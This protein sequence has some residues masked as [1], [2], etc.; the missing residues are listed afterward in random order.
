MND[1][2]WVQFLQEVLPRLHL[3]WQGFRKVR[4]QVCKRIGRRLRELGL[5]DIAAYADYLAA[6]PEEWQT[7]DRLCRISISRFY[8]DRGVFDALGNN[9]LPNLAD[10]ATRRGADTITIWS[11]GCASGE[12]PY[13]LQLLWTMRLAQQFPGLLLQIIATDTDERLLERAAQGV[14]PRGC[15]KELPPDWIA[16]A[17]EDYTGELRIRQDFRSGVTFV[18][19]DIRHECPDGPFDLILCR[20]LVFTYFDPALQRS[21]LERL[22]ARLRAGGCLIIGKHESLPATTPGLSVLEQGLPIYRRAA[23]AVSEAA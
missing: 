16:E 6:H 18:R 3:R 1:S 7:L 2:E 21:V 19:Q 9:V 14:Y 23:Q 20:N 8:R 10:A 11:A 13:T 15:L 5:T 12:E 22:V 4:K 17:F